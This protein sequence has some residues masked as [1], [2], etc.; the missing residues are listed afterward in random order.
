MIIGIDPGLTGA[1]AFYWPR[2]NE[3]H[4]EDMPTAPNKKGRRELLHAQL[5]HILKHP[6]EGPV[7]LE[8]VASRPGQGVSSVFRFGQVYGACEMAAAATGRPLHHVTP[9]A[10]KKHFNIA[11]GKDQA[12]GLASQRFPSAAH[13]FARKKDDGRAEACLLALYGAEVAKT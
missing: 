7:W 4:I 9:S 3:L 12:R 13:L 1:I 2:T 8:Q 6:I 11:A 5:A 10:W